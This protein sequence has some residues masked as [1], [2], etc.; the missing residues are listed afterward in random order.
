MDYPRPITIHFYQ[1]RHLHEALNYVNI[2]N[3][4]LPEIATIT[5]QN[6]VSLAFAVNRYPVSQ[7]TCLIAEE[8]GNIIASGIPGKN[9]ILF[10]A[11][12]Y[13]QNTK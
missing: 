8:N 13:F 2:I 11:E 10:K 5:I 9:E 1:F 7:N 12:R 3:A 4:D 6:S